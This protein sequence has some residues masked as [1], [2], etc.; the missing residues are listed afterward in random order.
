MAGG[1]ALRMLALSAAARRW[2]RPGWVGFVERQSWLCR[3]IWS[4]EPVEGRFVRDR[5]DVG[6]PRLSDCDRRPS[7]R[8]ADAGHLHAADR[9]Q[10]V[11]GRP[12]RRFVVHGGRLFR[13]ELLP[14]AADLQL[15]GRLL[16]GALA[17]VLSLAGRR[18]HQ[19]D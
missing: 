7:R 6:H 11:S 1:L 18:V 9:A 2:S 4:T 14:A 17:A 5:G 8:A 15:C 19:R 16:S 12:A 10:R 13:D 3:D